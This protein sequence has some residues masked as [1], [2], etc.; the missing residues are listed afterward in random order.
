MEC[1]GHSFL[2]PHKLVY[3]CYRAAFLLRIEQRFQ[4]HEAVPSSPQL[5]NEITATICPQW[6][7]AKSP[8]PLLQKPLGGGYTFIM[9]QRQL[10]AIEPT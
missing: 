6:V 5:Y 9:K 1:Q 2:F 4:S 10:G 7:P 3:F 8:T